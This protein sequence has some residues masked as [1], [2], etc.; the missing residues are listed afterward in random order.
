MNGISTIKNFFLF[1]YQKTNF[2]CFINGWGNKNC[3]WLLISFIF[4]LQICH[5]NTID[6]TMNFKN[7]K[8]I[9]NDFF[10]VSCD[11]AIE[12]FQLEK[13]LH[14]GLCNL[15]WFDLSVGKRESKVIPSTSLR[16]RE[17]KVLGNIVWEKKRHWRQRQIIFFSKFFFL[18]PDVLCE[19]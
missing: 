6:V 4:F 18:I 15:T 13:K 11:Y 2:L 14:S 16:W 9:E 5:L 1:I 8:T 12:V 10:N 3:L 7:I 17:C 19:N